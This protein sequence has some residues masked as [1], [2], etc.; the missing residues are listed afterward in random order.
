MTSSRPDPVFVSDVLQRMSEGERFSVDVEREALREGAR[1]VVSQR[2]SSG[3]PKAVVVLWIMA[4]FFLATVAVFAMLT[5]LGALGGS[6]G[7]R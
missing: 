4:S 7:F 5:L 2:R 6:I 3:M 1:A